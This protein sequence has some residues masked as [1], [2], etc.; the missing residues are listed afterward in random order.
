MLAC[1][2][3]HVDAAMKLIAPT[4][5]AGA[6]DLQDAKGR[7]CLMLASS[8]GL[9]GMVEALVGAGAK[10]ELTDERHCTSLLLAIEH[11]RLET[12]EALIGATAAAGALDCRGVVVVT[13]HGRRIENG[14]RVRSTE[15]TA[16]TGTVRADYHSKNCYSVQTMSCLMLASSQ[17]Q[18][19]MVEALVGAGA[20]AELVDEDKR[21]SFCLLYTSPSPRD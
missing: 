17:G 12:A 2:G 15:D 18:T 19:G 5:A 8:K 11:G 1:Q 3:Q 16:K 21:S 14:D 7:C 9:T 13:L 4:A 20:K 10:A 6:L